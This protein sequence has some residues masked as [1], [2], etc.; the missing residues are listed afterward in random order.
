MLALV[1]AVN[2][3]SLSTVVFID[4]VK[5]PLTRSSCAVHTDGQTDRR[6]AISVAERTTSM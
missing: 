1:L 5:R 4:S 6:K 2:V 3:K